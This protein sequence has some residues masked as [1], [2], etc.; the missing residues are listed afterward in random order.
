MTSAVSEQ[1]DNWDYN[2]SAKFWF[3]KMGVNV[4]YADTRNKITDFNWEPFQYKPI[5]PLAFQKEINNDTYQNGIAAITG[6]IHRGKYTGMYLVCL[7][8]DSQ[9]A[10]EAVFNEF[11]V[12]ISG[13]VELKAATPEQIAKDWIVE[14]HEGTKWKYHV[15]FI[16][17]F[18]F[19]N[20]PSNNLGLEVMCQERIVFVSNSI[21]KDGT[22]Y[23]ILGTRDPIALIE[24]AANEVKQ[25]LDQVFIRHGL[26]YLTSDNNSRLSY[27]LKQMTKTLTID[28]T[29]IISKGERNDTLL[30]LANSMLFQHYDNSKTKF[31]GKLKDCTEQ[32]LREF[33]DEINDKLCDYPLEYRELNRIWNN[34]LKFVQRERLRDAETWNADHPSVE[35]SDQSNTS[36]VEQMTEQL[37]SDIR[38]LTIEES[39]EILYYKNGAYVPGGEILIAKKAEEALKYKLNNKRLNEITDHIRRQTLHSREELDSDI[40]IKNMENGLYNIKTGELKPHTPDYLSISQ[41]PVEYDPNAARPEL[42]LKFLKEVLYYTDVGTVLDLMAYT[43]WKDDPYQILVFLHGQGL[44]GKNVFNFVLTQ[45]HGTRNVSNVSMKSMLE[46]PFS[47]ARL[48]NKYVN[49]DREVSSKIIIDT[50]ILKALSDRDYITIERKNKDPYEI[51]P[52]AKLIFCMNKIPKLEDETDSSIRRLILIAFPNQFEGKSDKVNL[53]YEL[54]TKTELTRIFALLMRLLRE[55]IFDS[56]GNEGKGRSIFMREQTLK[57]KRERHELHQNPTKMFL[58]LAIKQSE[59]LGGKI[60]T[61]HLHLNYQHFCKKNKIDAKSEENFAKELRSMGYH[62]ERESTRPKKGEKRRRYWEGIEWNLDDDYEPIEDRQSTL[63]SKP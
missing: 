41:L 15:M 30:S 28:P 24:D 31:A 46:R 34:A 40:N 44:N 33:Y 43:F 54:T 18:P 7:D 38:F 60:Y 35:K 3:Y 51:I 27:K 4:I 14:Y 55:I 11:P 9:K 8:F 20:M 23:N 6:K 52:F 17:P 12:K 50:T 45:L 39:N 36:L 1:S 62:V 59:N 29:M 42:F 48:E 19:P 21:H 5:T 56:E 22:H 16:S 47:L 61:D 10:F 2:S 57:Q 37:M 32:E 13:T 25:H 49:I 26:E 63:D 58:D 53:R